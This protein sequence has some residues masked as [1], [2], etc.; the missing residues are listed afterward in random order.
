MS[1]F[2]EFLVTRTWRQWGL[3]GGWF[4]VLGLLAYATNDIWLLVWNMLFFTLGM[5]LAIVRG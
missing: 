3:A 5:A 2:R 1:A 4:A